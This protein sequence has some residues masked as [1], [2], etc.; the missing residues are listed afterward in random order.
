MGDPINASGHEQEHF[1][2]ATFALIT[3]EWKYIYW[4]QKDF[5]QLFHRSKDP[6]DEYDILRNYYIFNEKESKQEFIIPE[7]REKIQGFNETVQT[8]VGDSIQSTTEIYHKL[9]ARFYELKKHVQ[10]GNRI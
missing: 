4:P 8:P 2:D 9:K 10:S 6:Y 5:E 3:E 7:E 1:I